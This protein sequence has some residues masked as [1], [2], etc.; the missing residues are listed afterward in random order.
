L[1]KL[2]QANVDRA[3]RERIKALKDARIKQGMTIAEVA[4]I[5]GVGKSVISKFENGYSDPRLSTVLRYAAVVGM[6]LYFE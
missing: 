6:D 5:V 2:P 4:A 3:V 1:V